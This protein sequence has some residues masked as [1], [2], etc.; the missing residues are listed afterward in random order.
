[1]PLNLVESPS[2]KAGDSTKWSAML[3]LKEEACAGAFAPSSM[4]D[5]REGGNMA[6]HEGGMFVESEFLTTSIWQFFWLLST[7][8]VHLPVVVT[9]TM[10]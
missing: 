10:M 3:S 8:T 6:V 2:W 9:C 1:M 4:A 7:A 5:V